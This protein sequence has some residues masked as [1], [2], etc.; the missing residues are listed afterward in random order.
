MTFGRGNKEIERKRIEECSGGRKS[1][2]GKTLQINSCGACVHH[3][4]LL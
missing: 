2:L 4:N 3:G 1:G